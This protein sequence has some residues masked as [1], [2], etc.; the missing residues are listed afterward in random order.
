[1]L[2][3]FRIFQGCFTVQLSRFFTV[4]S[5]ISFIILPKLL[6][7][8]K[9]FF[10]F[11]NSFFKNLKAI[12][13]CFQIFC[14]LKQLVYNSI[15]SAVCQQV[16]YI[17]IVFCKKFKNTFRSYN[18]SSITLFSIISIR[19]FPI[20]VLLNMVMTKKAIQTIASACMNPSNNPRT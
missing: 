14:S 19:S 10:Y 1:M 11:L 6:P 17:F 16:F 4:L 3:L 18:L 13:C 2:K 20:A 5:Q 9:N 15:L 12:L 7:F 8:V